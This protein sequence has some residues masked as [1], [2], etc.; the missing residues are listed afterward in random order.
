MEQYTKLLRITN[1]KNIKPTRDQLPVG[2]TLSAKYID[3]FVEVVSLIKVHTQEYS[4]P[5][6]V[7]NFELGTDVRPE[8]STTT[9]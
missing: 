1:L 6:G 8:V 7:L 4:N 5:G 3:T 9:L 2:F